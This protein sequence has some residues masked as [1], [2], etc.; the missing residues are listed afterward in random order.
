MRGEPAVELLIEALKDEDWYI[1]MKAADVL[2]NTGDK[3]AVEPL[4]AILKS[5]DKCYK[6][7]A[8]NAL[9]RIGL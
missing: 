1:R 4:I 3:R 9:S 2:G 7:E 6:W 8:K 5:E